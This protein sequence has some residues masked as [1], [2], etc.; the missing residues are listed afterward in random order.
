MT[1][2][3]RWLAHRH[4]RALL[5]GGDGVHTPPPAWSLVLAKD[6]AAWPSQACSTRLSARLQRRLR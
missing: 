3:G 1:G 6:A 4:E 2:L 5:S